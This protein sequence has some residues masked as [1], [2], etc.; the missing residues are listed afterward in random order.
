MCMELET[1][2]DNKALVLDLSYGEIPYPI[3]LQIPY[4]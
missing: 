1:N 4:S 3:W 2:K